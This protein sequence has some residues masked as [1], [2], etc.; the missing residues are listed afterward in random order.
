MNKYKLLPLVAVAILTTG[1]ANTMMSNNTQ[2]KQNTSKNALVG[3]S[4]ESQLEATK[5]A[6]DDQL[7]L[8]K[9][10]K[11]GK[12]I[13][14]YNMVTHNNNV[15]ARVDS[16]NTVPLQYGQQNVPQSSSLNESKVDTGTKEIVKSND[17]VMTQKVKRIVWK[18]DSLNTLA[19]NLAKSIGFD[20]VTKPSEKGVADANVDYSVE[21][22]TV[23]EAISELSKKAS[24][25]ADV[26]VFE[27]NKTVNV[28]YK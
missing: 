19:K 21:N 12:E 1:C 20:F 9:A 28:L 14:S 3:M 22:V 26:L 17:V 5:K 23:K 11:S 27:E 24:G 16:S 2:N 18:N 8:L 10:V 25:V 7:S 6:L 4:V 13:E 15:D